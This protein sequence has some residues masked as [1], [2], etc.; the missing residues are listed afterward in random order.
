M[1]SSVSIALKSSG[2]SEVQKAL[3]GVKTSLIELEKD[4]LA[5]VKAASKSRIDVLEAEHHKRIDLAKRTA[6]VEDKLNRGFGKSPSTRP[7]LG[8]SGGFGSLSATGNFA[9]SQF[10]FGGL[11]S[12][13]KKDG[14]SG[15]T[16]GFGVLA[17]KGALD[18]A[19]TALK[20]FG[21]FLLN[22]VIKPELDLNTKYHQLSAKSAELGGRGLTAEQ[23]QKA[24][25]DNFVKWNLSKEDGVKAMEAYGSHGGEGA[26]SDAPK[27]LELAAKEA[28]IRGGSAETYAKVIAGFRVKGESSD[29]TI[30]KYLAT[31]RQGD[32]MD[33]P[34]EELQNRGKQIKAASLFMGG[35]SMQ[36][37]A[38]ANV[39]VQKSSEWNADPASAITGLNN[40]T[41]AVMISAKKV[42]YNRYKK[43]IERDANGNEVIGNAGHLVGQVIHDMNGSPGKLPELGFQD[44]R[45]QRFVM[46]STTEYDS[47]KSQA[48]GEGLTDKNKIN[49][50]ALELWN[51]AFDKST[52]ET[53]SLADINAEAA[54][55]MKDSGQQMQQA[56]NQIKQSLATHVMPMVS[57]FIDDFCKNIDSITIAARDVATVLMDLGSLISGISNF[58]VGSKIRGKKDGEV[59]DTIK[60]PNKNDLPPLFKET[61]ASKTAQLLTSPDALFTN[62]N[63]YYRLNN[64]GEVITVKGDIPN[65]D[66]SDFGSTIGWGDKNN[67]Q[68]FVPGGSNSINTHD[69]QNDKNTEN[70]S[71]ADINKAVEAN[72]AAINS[73][74]DASKKAADKLSALNRLKSI[75]NYI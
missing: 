44:K 17:L 46:S 47:Y 14:M 10:G 26:W 65:K 42:A 52:K 35:T 54:E 71:V 1:S 60:D 3:K 23:A 34:V 29:D 30:A 8:G 41:S 31:R 33:V 59:I 58:W 75:L 63:S 18:M 74:G 53:D 37:F 13:H 16:L 12:L 20:T 50:R 39:L 55:R 48:R 66:S 49:D 25:E 40:F 15:L 32:I 24:A 56:I 9:S 4:S 6:E 70:K 28:L 43:F 11:S 69:P 68:V 64:K 2:I 7:A 73:L 36:K 22:D 61:E 21:S 67:T 19:T 45:E 51:E 72:I 38:T 27:I 57:K 62:A 5:A